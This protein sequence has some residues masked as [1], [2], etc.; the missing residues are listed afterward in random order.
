MS[1][2]GPTGDSSPR[3][4]TYGAKQSGSTPSLT[5]RCTQALR[6]V[7]IRATLQLPALELRV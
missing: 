1:P 5:K 4:V 2:R 3:R 7:S 6:P